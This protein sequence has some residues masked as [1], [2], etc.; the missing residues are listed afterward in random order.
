MTTR[1]E[2]PA[3]L[4]TIRDLW[5]EYKQDR[6]EF[7]SRIKRLEIVVALVLVY[8]MGQGGAS[9]LSRFLG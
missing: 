5:D 8:A 4:L 7:D 9:L 6:K 2:P 1:D 3:L